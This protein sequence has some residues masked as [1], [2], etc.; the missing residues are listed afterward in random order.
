MSAGLFA[1]TTI[2]IQLLHNAKNALCLITD[3]TNQFI[4]NQI[5]AY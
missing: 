2:P 5:S 3:R 1:F 4:A